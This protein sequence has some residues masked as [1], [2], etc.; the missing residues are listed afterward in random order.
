M[1]TETF[2]LVS[3]RIRKTISWVDMKNGGQARVNVAYLI[4]I[5]NKLSHVNS[6]FSVLRTEVP[7]IKELSIIDGNRALH[8]LAMER[9][10]KELGGMY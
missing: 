2:N 3:I 7:N 1:K 4:K 8:N 9:I 5:D 6:G 10:A